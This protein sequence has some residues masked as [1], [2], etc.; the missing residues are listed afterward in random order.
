MPEWIRKTRNYSSSKSDQRND[1]GNE[2]I[3]E[4]YQSWTSR[5]T[6]DPSKD[7]HYI[8]LNPPINLEVLRFS[9]KRRLQKTF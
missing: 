1:R 6:D 8:R 7:R 4:R 5:Q 2:K 9:R 3:E